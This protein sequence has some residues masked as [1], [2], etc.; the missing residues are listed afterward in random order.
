M[1]I[2]AHGDIDTLQATKKKLVPCEKNTCRQT[3]S[4][5]P[6]PETKAALHR[7][8]TGNLLQHHMHPQRQASFPR[9]A[10]SNLVDISAKATTP[11]ITR[12][13]DP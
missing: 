9:R 12:L 11:P 1:G 6:T 13:R 8:H 5:S 7:N 10:S 2:A 3:L 4:P